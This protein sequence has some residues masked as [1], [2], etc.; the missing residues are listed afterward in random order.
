MELFKDDFEKERKERI[1]A[2]RQQ[3]DFE[4]KLFTTVKQLEKKTLEVRLFILD[5]WGA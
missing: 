5:F 1:F 2:Q 4:D 3:K